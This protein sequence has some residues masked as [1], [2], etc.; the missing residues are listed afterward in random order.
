MQRRFVWPALGLVLIG[1]AFFVGR[2]DAQG[3]ATPGSSQDPLASVSYVG[4]AVQNALTQQVPAL[5]TQGIQS[6]LPGVV[7]PLVQ[8]TVQTDVQNA[9]AT[10]PQGGGSEQVAVVS[11]PPGQKLV[12]QQGT[13]F[14]LRGGN[15]TV[16]LSPTSAGGFSDLTGGQD[17]GQGASV[18]MNHLLLAAR[19]DGRA[20]TPV[21][22]VRLLVI[23]IGQ[24]TLE[25]GS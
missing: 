5:V 13:E 14:I 25:P 15:G 22:N 8:S 11:V 1:C 17:L 16:S 7:T 10:L 3:S 18:P 2:A 9:I 4:Q 12:A 24:Y 19:S 20:I 6:A 21:G 23:V